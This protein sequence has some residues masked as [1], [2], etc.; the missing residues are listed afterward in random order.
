MNPDKLKLSV[1]ELFEKVRSWREH[2]HRHPEPSFQEKN[3]MLFVSEILSIYGIE[4]ETNVAETGVV[5]WIGADH[6]TKEQPC[7]GLRADLDALPIHEENDVPY[8]SLV[9]GWMHACGHDVHTSILLGSAVILQAN[10]NE[11]PQPIKLIFQPGEEMNPGGASLMMKAGVLHHPEV[12]KLYAL[13]VFPEMEVGNIGL[14][15]GLYM[16]SSDELHVQIKGVGGHGALPEKCVNPIEMGALWMS[17]VKAR[18]K[19]ECPDAVPHV[20]TFGRF[21][22]L[23]STNVIPSEA[24]IKGT[25][26]TMDEIWRAKAYTILADEANEVSTLFGG[27]I[28]LNISKGYPFLKNDETLTADL[29]VLFESVFGS[30]HIHELALRMTAE[31]FAFYSQEIPVCFFRLGVGNK[32]KGITHAVHHPRFDIDSDA[33]KMGMMAMC[34]IAFQE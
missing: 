20:L 24:L 26:R 11:L 22:A 27:E 32:A 30:D 2:M 23:G 21:E 18:F 7:I 31:D 3:T 15:S 14:R 28:A 17:R 12:V 5:A 16:A 19:E 29:K 4:H 1:S 8:K 10:R 6:H 13:H 34:S 25:F 9:D 33:L